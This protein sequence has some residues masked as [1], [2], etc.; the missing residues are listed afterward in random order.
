[1]RSDGPFGA[2]NGGTGLES[3]APDGSREIE[4]R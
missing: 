1:M 4:L 3:E 2:S